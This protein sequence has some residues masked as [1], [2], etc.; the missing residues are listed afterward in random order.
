MD[1]GLT[2]RGIDGGKQRGAVLGGSA[3]LGFS[4]SSPG[5]SSYNLMIITVLQSMSVANLPAVMGCWTLEAAEQQFVMGAF[6]KAR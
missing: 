3:N 5:G 4:C 2:R 1:L 6:N